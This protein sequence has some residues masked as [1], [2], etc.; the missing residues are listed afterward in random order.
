MVGRLEQIRKLQ[1]A[2]EKTWIV[3][4]EDC[5]GM[6]IAFSVRAIEPSSSVS[7]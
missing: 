3:V 2:L 1:K 4:A 5:R 7:L 6:A